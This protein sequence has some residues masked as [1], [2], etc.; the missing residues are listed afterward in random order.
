MRPSGRP[1]KPPPFYVQTP[2]ICSVDDVKQELSHALR[3]ETG[4]GGCQVLRLYGFKYT[5]NP[6]ET[7]EP[8]PI[9]T[10]VG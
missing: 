9:V 2:M 8:E 4:P 1:R 6:S 7:P 10:P 3:K 5:P